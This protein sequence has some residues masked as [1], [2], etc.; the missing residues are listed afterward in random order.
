MSNAL[1]RLITAAS[2]LALLA[3][4]TEADAGNRRY[5]PKKAKRH[6]HQPWNPAATG[7]GILKA[8]GYGL[9]AS[10][11]PDGQ[12]GSTFLGAEVGTAPSP[13]VQVG[14]TLDWLRR[15][16]ETGEYYLIDTPYDLPVQGALNL[17]ATSTDLIPLGGI[18]RLRYP[19]ADGTFVPFISGQ[20]TYDV[21]RLEYR[22]VD[23]DG[24]FSTV[25]QQTDYFHGLGTTVSLGFEAVID[26]SVGLM[27]E[28]GVHD[29][30]PTQGL[31]VDDFPVDARVNAG[32]EFL[33]IGLRMGLS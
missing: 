15:R 2:V 18:V 4:A 24:P 20:L 10:L 3:G 1:P 28:V 5:K 31:F 6:Y 7:Y 32:G 17:E 30:E 14:F 26:P 8:G 16:N 29:S 11:T 13:F 25:A 22:A 9:D 19:V 21:L 12:F 23:T 27:F 33:R